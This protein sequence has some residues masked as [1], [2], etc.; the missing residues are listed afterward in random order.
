MFMMNLSESAMLV[1]PT[2]NSMQ[3]FESLKG[4]YVYVNGQSVYTSLRSSGMFSKQL[5]LHLYRFALNSCTY[6]TLFTSWANFHNTM[7]KKWKKGTTSEDFLASSYASWVA[8]LKLTLERLALPL[9]NQ[10][11]YSRNLISYERYIDW[12][13]TLGVVPV[14]QVPENKTTIQ[15][16]EDNLKVLVNTSGP[17]DK[18]ITEMISSLIQ[19]MKVILK[20]LSSLYIPDYSEVSIHKNLESGEWFGIYK[21]KRIPVEVMAAPVLCKEG[22]MFDSCVQRVFPTVMQCYRTQEHAKLCQLLNTIPVKTIVGNAQ[23]PGYKDILEHLEK[24]NSKTDPKK[25]LLNLLINLAENKTVSGVTD[26]VEDFISDVSNNL[27]DRNK[28]FG[29]SNET[30]C[31]GLKKQVS[32]SVFKCLTKQINEQFDTIAD[33]KKERELYL[34]RLQTVES[35]LLRI[36]RNEK[37]IH[38]VDVNLLTADTMESLSEVRD[39][40]LLSSTTEVPNGKSVLNSFFSQYVPP[41]RELGKDLANLWESE[42]MSTFKLVP[43]VDPQGKMICVRYTPDTVSLLLGPFTYVITKLTSMDLIRDDMTSQS[44]H[45]LVDIVYKESRLLVYITDIGSKLGTEVQLSTDG[46][47]V[48]PP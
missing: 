4:K 36:A 37:S 8:T 35:H 47:E 38:D 7:R 27:I 14:A 23:S 39:L 44:V 6:E 16:L 29:N 10:L 33:L 30:T 13:T 1:H 12:V 45:G 40:N 15:H 24:S 2:K 25:E 17:G 28:L 26:V 18:V 46:V 48:L 3:L 34:A 42:L 41:F 22:Y 20:T 5:F 32:N 11:Q 21:S 9:I 19:E 31:A 43:E